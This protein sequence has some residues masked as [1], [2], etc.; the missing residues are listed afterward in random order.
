MLLVL[1]LKEIM[2]HVNVPLTSGGVGGPAGRWPQVGS[3]RV[4][5][6]LFVFP[7]VFVPSQSWESVLLGNREVPWS[8]CLS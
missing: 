3:Q 6:P 7:A 2:S 4:W 8:L 1:E 5:A